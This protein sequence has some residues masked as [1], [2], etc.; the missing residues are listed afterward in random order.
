MSMACVRSSKGNVVIAC[1]GFGYFASCGGSR[2]GLLGWDV[3]TSGEGRA[4]M[5]LEE[6]LED[7]ARVEGIT[8]AADEMRPWVRR[9]MFELSDLP[10]DCCLDRY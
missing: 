10:G 8:L 9:R 4:W 1:C 2:V 3:E 6:A 5:G 7:L